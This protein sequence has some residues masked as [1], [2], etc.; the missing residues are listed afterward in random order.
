[1]VSS[2]FVLSAV[3]LCFALGIYQAYISLAVA[4]FLTYAIKIA[5]TP[6]CD[7]KRVLTTGL[8]AIGVI[9]TALVMYFLVNELVMRLSRVEY[10]SYAA[11]AIRPNIS[12]G[13]QAAYAMFKDSVNNGFMSFVPSALSRFAFKLLFVCTVIECAVLLLRGG[14]AI[15]FIFAG[16]MVYIFPLAVNCLL[17]ASPIPHPVEYFSFVC[18]YVLAAVVADS[19]SGARLRVGGEVAAVLLAVILLDGVYFANTVYLKQKLNYEQAYGFYSGIVAQIKR[20][21]EYTYGD[22]IVLAGNAVDGFITPDE[23][24]VNND[25]LPG[26]RDEMINVYSRDKLINYYLGF[27]AEII[28]LAEVDEC[29]PVRE[30]YES[31]SVYPSEGSVEKIENY[32]IVKLS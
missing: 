20:L 13:I 12:F 6:E 22:T 19:F 4:L 23:L 16:V 29:V 31:M 1:M 10:N 25:E 14:S 18:V 30:L 28:D 21:P 15:K 5:L 3:S 24:K 9:I 26:I 27:D 32:I 8:G 2:R 17:V 7:W 11:G